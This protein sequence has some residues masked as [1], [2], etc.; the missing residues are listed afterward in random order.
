MTLFTDVLQ[1]PTLFEGL[2]ASVQQIAFLLVLPILIM[3]VLHENLIQ[4]EGEGNYAG[5]FVRVLVVLGLLILYK[6]FFIMI[7]H[8]MDL[9]SKTIMPDQEFNHVVKTIFTEIQKNKD[10]G[11]FNFFKAALINTISYS[12]YLLTYIAYTILIWLR[13]MLLSVLYV[14]G[15]ILIVFGIFPKTAGALHS[16]LK[17]LIQISAWIVTLSL[18]VRTASYMDLMSIYSL[19]NVNTVSIVTANVLFVLLFVFTPAITSALI[20]EGSIGNIGSTMIGIGTSVS[21][22]FLQKMRRYGGNAISNLRNRDDLQDK[23]HSI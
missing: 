22:A 20:S 13:F 11:V 16:W 1:I 17:S 7:T 5:L 10:F 15:P 14:A 3:A 18:L 23:T 4:M 6:S 12:T 19:D 21:Y 2:H 8:G 9:L